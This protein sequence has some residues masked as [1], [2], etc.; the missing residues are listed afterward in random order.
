M[1]RLS[2]IS[3]GR[4]CPHICRWIAPRDK[5][6]GRHPSRRLH[7]SGCCGVSRVHSLCCLG[8]L[9]DAPDA[10]QAPCKCCH[11]EDESA[12]LGKAKPVGLDATKTTLQRSGMSCLT[13]VR[14]SVC[15]ERDCLHQ[16][17]VFNHSCRLSL[18]VCRNSGMAVLLSACAMTHLSAF[19]PQT[20]FFCLH[21]LLVSVFC[22]SPLPI[23]QTS[24]ACF[25]SR[26]LHFSS[27]SPV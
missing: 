19:H 3:P 1:A 2:N 10:Q 24:T 20:S 26:Q 6:A 25:V 7:H 11:K 17:G 15:T 12:R 21:L 5:L 4:P 23:F 22:C 13:E 18:H 8:S 9:H 27:C 14:L 16:F